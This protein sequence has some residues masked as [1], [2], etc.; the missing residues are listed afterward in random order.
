LVMTIYAYFFFEDLDEIVSQ[1]AW[2]YLI[3][4]AAGVLAFAIYGTISV[5]LVTREKGCCAKHKYTLGVF[6]L[7][8]FVLISVQTVGTFVAIFWVKDSYSFSEGQYTTRGQMEGASDKTRT[9]IGF[10][11]ESL[12]KAIRDI[13]AVTC[14]S[15]KKCCYSIA[16]DETATADSATQ[17]TRQSGVTYLEE[18][19]PCDKISDEAGRCNPGL[20]NE[21]TQEADTALTCTADDDSA[22]TYDGIC[23][24]LAAGTC[25]DR[26]HDDNAGLKVCDKFDSPSGPVCGGRRSDGEPTLGVCRPTIIDA[27]STFTCVASHAGSS[28][29][30]AANQ[31]SDPSNPNFCQLLSGNNRKGITPTG[32]LCYAMEKAGVMEGMKEDG[33]DEDS[34]GDGSLEQ[35]AADFCDSGVS[36]YESYVSGIFQWIHEQ[37]VPIGVMTGVLGMLEFLQM[38]VCLGMLFADRKDL[39]EGFDGAKKWAIEEEKKL[40]GKVRHRR[41][42]R[43]GGGNHNQQHGQPHDDIPPPSMPPAMP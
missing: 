35:C 21:V 26:R 28:V 39:H 43:Q 11:D 41:Q 4:L 22:A 24:T 32:A 12:D 25:L 2:G 16:H 29:G 19:D 27:D 30:A 42:H 5:C 40:K 1:N 6:C 34:I 13:E 14:N 7:L 33:D 31:L 3:G 17:L 18:G 23:T 38:C 15:Y 10:I 20:F 8:L 9:G 37:V 36:G